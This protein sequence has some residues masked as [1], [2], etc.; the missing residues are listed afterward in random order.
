MI[1]HD[2]LVISTPLKHISQMGV[3][4]PLCKKKKCSKPPTRSYSKLP[5]FTS[6]SF[7]YSILFHHIYI[8]IYIINLPKTQ[9]TL[10]FV[11]RV[12]A[13]RH[14]G[15]PGTRMALKSA[16]AEKTEEALRRPPK[17]AK[18]SVEWPP[19]WAMVNRLL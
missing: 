12:S 19:G 4:F 15:A 18:T 7:T 9:V 13:W 14:P 8:Y 6:L 5:T 17:T 16:K 11:H 2:W 3:F 1:Y 10:D